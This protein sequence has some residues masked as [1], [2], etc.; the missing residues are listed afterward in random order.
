MQNGVASVK[1]MR[2]FA[3][4]GYL[5]NA[6]MVSNEAVKELKRESFNSETL[7]T[8]FYDKRFQSDKEGVTRVLL[9]ETGEPAEV[10][11]EV[12]TDKKMKVQSGKVVSYYD[13]FVYKNNGDKIGKKTFYIEHKSKRKKMKQG[14][15][16]SRDNDYIG[17]GIREDQ[18]Q[19]ET[20]FEEG[21]DYIP[22]TSYP[23][24]LQYHLKMGFTPIQHLR[25][26]RCKADVEKMLS[27]ILDEVDDF[28]REKVTPV[29]AEKRG[30]FGKR[31]FLDENT[32]LALTYLRTVKEFFL[33][34]KNV[35]RPKSIEGDNVELE[36]KGDNL[37]VWRNILSGKPMFD[38]IN[39][40]F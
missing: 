22:R 37:K 20:A 24:A 40:V 35:P 21:I 39:N 33:N 23:E 3:D 16:E 27:D 36:L 13:V 18:K 26:V 32:T 38:G 29:I 9:R 7:R 12:E 31:Y 25:R 6:L 15:M 14:Y 10:R 2:I 1:V 4:T 11:I 5:K 8:L 19:I 34:N 28:T 30:L 17:L